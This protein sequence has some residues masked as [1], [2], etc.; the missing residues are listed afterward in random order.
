MSAPTCQQVFRQVA[1]DWGILYVDPTTP[2]NQ[3]NPMR[4]LDLDAGALVLTATFQ[5]IA[6]TEAIDSKTQPGGAVLRVPTAVTLTVTDGSTTISALT[7][8]ATWQL[9]CTIRIA[10]DDQD[11]ELLTSTLLARPFV[12][13]GGS[14]TATVY[15]DAVTL[16]VNVGKV[17]G[18]MLLGQAHQWVTEAANRSDFLIRG[19]WPLDPI[20]VPGWS[21]YPFWNICAKP[22][23]AGPTSFFLDGYYDYTQSTIVR[24]IRLSPMPTVRQSIGWTSAINP[25]RVTAEDLDNAQHA[26][27]GVKIPCANGFIES[28]FLPIARQYGSGYPQFKNEEMRAEIRRQYEDAIGRLKNIGLSSAPARTQYV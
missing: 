16:P 27:P 23:A 20:L 7:T 25:Q 21:N 1:R 11:N 15:C 28:I 4:A 6:D 12:G 3:T 9:G 17:V 13:T 22:T 5:K 8:Y 18:P 10:G 19:G 2:A 24:R 26:D 14:V